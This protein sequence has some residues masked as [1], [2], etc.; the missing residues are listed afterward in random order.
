[1]VTNTGP[2]AAIAASRLS[3]AAA[4]VNRSAGFDGPIANTLAS[5]S[6]CRSGM[7]FR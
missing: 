5:A 6:A 1:M 4:T 3:V 7:L 2:S